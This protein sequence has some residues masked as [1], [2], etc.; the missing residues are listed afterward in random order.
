MSR[1]QHSHPLLVVT[2]LVCAALAC[3]GSESNVQPDDLQNSEPVP[4]TSGVFYFFPD[5]ALF[6]G[7]AA[8]GALYDFCSPP[9][10]MDDGNGYLRVSETGVLDGFCSSVSKDNTTQREG[11]LTGE[12]SERYE[13]VSFK[14][15]ITRVFM[16]HPDGKVTAKIVFEGEGTVANKVA[17][18]TGNYTYICTAEGELVY[19]IDDRTTLSLSGTMPF[20]LEFKP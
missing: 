7:E 3:S 9:S 14:L 10:T 5:Q 1:P 12:Y 20:Q 8:P 4:F 16:P 17:T 13:D 18:G 15:E 11:R 6:T 19:C 2:T